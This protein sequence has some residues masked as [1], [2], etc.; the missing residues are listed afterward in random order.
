MS[1]SLDDLIS[2]SPS[3]CTTTPT[4]DHVNFGIP[5]PKARRV[6]LFSSS[7]WEDFIEEWAASL[8]PTTYARIGKFSGSGDMGLDVVGFTTVRGFADPWDN[9]QCKHYDHSLNLSDIRK[10]FS[11]II[12]YSFKGEYTVPRKSYFVAPLDV[13]T[14]LQQYFANPVKLKE[15]I[16]DNW[17]EKISSTIRAPL[18]GLLL[19]WFDAFD[20]TAF[21]TKSVVELLQE[22]EKT[23]FHTVRF[24]GGL[25]LRPKADLPPDTPSPDESIYIEQLFNAYS[26]YLGSG[27]KTAVEL[28]TCSDPNLKDDFL[29]QRVR[30]YSAESLKNF[31]RDKVPDG[32]FEELQ[33]EIFNGVV[34][35]SCAKHDNGVVRMH[36]TLR[37]STYLNLTSNPLIGAL[38][39]EDRQG[40][41]HQ[42]A[43]KRELV[44]VPKK[45]VEK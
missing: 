27:V 37:E 5:I 7:D 29:R 11:K 15:E 9:Y 18:E 32:T 8:E 13:T 1:I 36:E 34:D 42:L 10:E 28:S 33:K 21:T 22:H 17:D 19:D 20:F 6:Q 3:S 38:R 41:C 16:K 23:P 30:F 25:P 31:V 4:A 24:G 12:Y 39:I 26:D 45:E 2:I 14:T 44:W 40:I 35:V 43:N